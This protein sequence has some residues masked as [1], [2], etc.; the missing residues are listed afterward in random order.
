MWLRVILYLFVSVVFVKSSK[1]RGYHLYFGF[2]E[3]LLLL[4]QLPEGHFLALYFSFVLNKSLIGHFF[5]MF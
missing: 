1:S 5:V 2:Y 3:L 4:P